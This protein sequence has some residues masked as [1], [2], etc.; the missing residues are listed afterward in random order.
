MERAYKMFVKWTGMANLLGGGVLVALSRA[1]L[2]KMVASGPGFWVLAGF[3]SFSGAVLVWASSDPLERAPVIFWEGV[4]R[5]WAALS[6][7]LMPDWP[8]AKVVVLGDGSIGSIY[9]LGLLL[10][11][12][13]SLKTAICGQASSPAK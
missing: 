11:M 9:I 10:V 4:L 13:V 7:T 2:I 5:L 3:L 6:F 8:L 1:P 12:R